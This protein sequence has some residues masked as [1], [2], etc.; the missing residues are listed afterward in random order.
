MGVHGR[1]SIVSLPVIGINVIDIAIET[2]LKELSSIV[3]K[4]IHSF[5][6]FLNFRF[7][8]SFWNLFCS[9]FVPLFAFL[10]ILSPDVFSFPIVKFPLLLSL[11]LFHGFFGPS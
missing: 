6:H 11:P 8:F 1:V 3:F 4:W 2:I 10:S 9:V 5:R 7:S